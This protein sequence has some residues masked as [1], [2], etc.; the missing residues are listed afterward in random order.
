MIKQ[1]TLENFKS[2]K[3]TKLD[4]VPGINVI[5][6]KSLS[7]KTNIFRGLNWV[8]TNR[9]SGFNFKNKYTSSPRVTVTIKTEDHEIS[10]SKTKSTMK[11][12]VDGHEYKKAG[13]AVPDEVTAAL[14]LN[15]I[16]I[17]QQL[18]S[19]FLINSPTSQIS[20]FI[21]K[22]TGMEKVDGWV[23][24]LTKEINSKTSI[25]SE[26][27]KEI[28]RTTSRLKKY[29][30]LDKV[31][32]LQSEYSM[33]LDRFNQAVQWWNEYWKFVEQ[34][35]HK[36]ALLRISKMVD[37][38][39]VKFTEIDNKRESLRL[40]RGYTALRDRMKRQKANLK[41]QKAIITKA[42]NIVSDTAQKRRAAHLLATYTQVCLDNEETVSI[43]KDRIEEYV[44]T[45][46]TVQKCPI[47]KSKITA[48][49]V[50]DLRK[51]LYNESGLSC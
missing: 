31:A 46:K 32:A 21:N 18:D 16:N 12:I 49:C 36:K 50:S 41:R 48:K 45:V 30:G 10:L 43:A 29:D 4:F 11:Y 40:I 17:Q 7:G 20:K 23:A 33:K 8:R 6:G 14:H 24:Q 3:K 1:I 27:E 19:P 34:T 26:M 22:F 44:K 28:R 42:E 9:P 13:K 25:V 5:S 2:H 15:D 51:E 35:R 47:C 39:K 38:V 37:K